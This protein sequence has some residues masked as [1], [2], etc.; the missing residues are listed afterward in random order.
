MTEGGLS[1]RGA[2]DEAI[3]Q[4]EVLSILSFG[5]KENKTIN[6]FNNFSGLPRFARNDEG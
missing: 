6:L 2:C 3:Q 1:L 4:H 5:F